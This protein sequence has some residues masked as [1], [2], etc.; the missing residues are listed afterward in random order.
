M[1][2]APHLTFFRLT[3]D[4]SRCLSGCTYWLSGLR[5]GLKRERGA[6]S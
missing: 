2:S 6:R 1:P 5:A 4:P 3:G